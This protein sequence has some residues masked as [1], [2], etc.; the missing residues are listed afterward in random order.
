[1]IRFLVLTV[2][3]LLIPHKVNAQTETLETA[4]L[5]FELPNNKWSLE[6]KKETNAVTVY[7]Y[8]REPIINKSGKEIIPTISFVIETIQDST[9]IIQYSIAKR[10]KVPFTVTEVFSST[11][12][13]AYRDQVKY[14]GRAVFTYYT[15]EENETFKGKVKSIGTTL[16]E[17]YAAYD[18][19]AFKGNLKTAGPVSFTRFGS[20][21]DD[22]SKEKLKTVET[23]VFT[24]YGS[25]DD[26]AFKGKIKSIERNVFTYY[27][28]YDRKEYSGSLKTG[29]PILYVNNIKF[30]VRN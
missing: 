11:D 30:L 9:D 17:Y 24:Y 13:E 14:V 7:F 8:K 6:D 18:D 27:S 1:M 26:K 16:F 22:A 4:N 5:Q 25:F 23:T 29:S 2:G 28:S 12:N 20:F 15:A 19:K 21:G 10:M 3:Y